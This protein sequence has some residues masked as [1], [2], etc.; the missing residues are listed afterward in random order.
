MYVYVSFVKSCKKFFN[1]DFILQSSRSSR[2]PT[3]T[4]DGRNTFLV[5][6]AK[7]NVPEPST[8]NRS[9]SP[10]RQNEEQMNRMVAAKQP[11]ESSVS[12]NQSKFKYI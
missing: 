6:Q 10:N 11:I 1:I 12:F 9:K 7:Q 2:S 8:R 4:N 3:P 5:P